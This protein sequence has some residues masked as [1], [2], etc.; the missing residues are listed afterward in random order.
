[1]QIKGPGGGGP[2][3]GPDETQKPASSELGKAPSAG[4]GDTIEKASRTAFG[5]ALKAP[6]GLGASHVN[7]G[8]TGHS[9]GAGH[10]NFSN[11]KNFDKFQNHLRGLLAPQGDFAAKPAFQDFAS[12]MGKLL[13]AVETVKRPGIDPGKGA[14]GGGGTAHANN[15]PPEM[16]GASRT[17]LPAGQLAV[18]GVGGTASHVNSGPTGHSNGAG[19]ANFSREAIFD[20]FVNV[21]N[22][23]LDRAASHVNSGPTGHSNGAGHANFADRHGMDK[24]VNVAQGLAPGNAASHVNSGPTGHSNGAG[25]ANFADRSV[26][27]QIANPATR[28]GQSLGIGNAA[29]HVNSGPTGHSN[30]AGHANFADDNR[31]QQYVNEFR[32]VLQQGRA[33]ILGSAAASH[34]N[35]GPTGHSNGAGHANFSD[36]SNPGGNIGNPGGG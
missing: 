20:K 16:G 29:S 21:A 26:M 3:K 28:A 10:A 34:V 5:D 6:G 36:V 25:H 17:T 23:L 1:M 24:F 19:H 4:P 14:I 32:E 9:N 33:S 13:D 15:I 7:S 8:P 27:D 22:T 12:K 11:D 18:G 31:F 30:G 2:I 35:S